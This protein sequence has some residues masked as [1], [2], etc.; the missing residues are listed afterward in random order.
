VNKEEIKKY[1]DDKF[2]PFCKAD[3]KF[4][5]KN[6]TQ[7]GEYF[8]CSTCGKEWEEVTGVINIKQI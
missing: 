2:C 6:F 7:F 5:V 1:N 3:N 4:V 8:K